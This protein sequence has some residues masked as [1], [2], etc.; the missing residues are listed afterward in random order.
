MFKILS[1]PAVHRP[2][3]GSPAT[4]RKRDTISCLCMALVVLLPDAGLAET[5]PDAERELDALVS[6]ANECLARRYPA[7]DQAERQQPVAATLR[8]HGVPAQWL[9]D[10]G[11]L[12]RHGSDQQRIRALEAEVARLKAQLEGRNRPSLRS[13][14]DYIEDWEERNQ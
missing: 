2:L 14:V 3:A 7:T 4:R 13:G 5:G 1:M 12:D 6:L 11:T 10:D 9:R 8:S